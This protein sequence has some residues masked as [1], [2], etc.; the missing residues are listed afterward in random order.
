MKF[1]TMCGAAG[2]TALM[3]LPIGTIRANPES[4]ALLRDAVAEAVAVAGAQGV[5][6]PA[7]ATE[8]LMTGID[9]YRPSARTSMAEDLESGRRLELDSLNG[10]LVRLGRE[11]GVP[12]P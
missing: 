12:T 2:L 4:R 1:A 9:S 3:R 5:S 10:A 8:R 11:L 6:L 7:D